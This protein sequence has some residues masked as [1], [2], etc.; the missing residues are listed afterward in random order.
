MICFEKERRCCETSHAHAQIIKRRWPILHT[1]STLVPTTQ[2]KMGPKLLFLLC[3]LSPFILFLLKIGTL[4]PLLVFVNP[5]EEAATGATVRGGGTD[6]YNHRSNHHMLRTMQTS[7]IQQQQQQSTKIFPLSDRAPSPVPLHITK[8]TID[9]VDRRHLQRGDTTMVTIQSSSSPSSSTQPTSSSTPKPPSTLNRQKPSS[10]TTTKTTVTSATKQTPT[11]TTAP[12]ESPKQI[13]EPISS[14][15]PSTLS[16]PLP[17]PKYFFV[18]ILSTCT[19]M[20]A[21]RRAHLRRWMRQYTKAKSTPTTNGNR[22]NQRGR[23]QQKQQKQPVTE[24]EPETITLDYLFILD[25]A[26]QTTT[27]ETAQTTMTKACE[28]EQKQFGD[29]LFLPMEASEVGYFNLAYKVEKV[30][31]YMGDHNLFDQYRYFVKTDDDSI[32]R[33]D[34]YRKVLEK[35]VDNPQ[36]NKFRQ[37]LST[38]TVVATK[39]NAPQDGSRSMTMN[40]V[41]NEQQQKRH[42]LLNSLYV[43][44]GSFEPRNRPVMRHGIRADI[45]FLT[46]TGLRTYSKYAAGAIYAVS[47]ALGKTLY[48]ASRAGPLIKWVNE[49]A[50]FGHWVSSYRHIRHNVFQYACL[51]PSSRRWCH[52]RKHFIIHPVKRVKTMRKMIQAFMVRRNPGLAVKTFRKR[53][54]G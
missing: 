14:P 29:M 13:H 48:G 5:W 18:A 43:Y 27:S 53:Y 6:R 11:P 38:A 16:P 25:N 23:P 17:A 28:E 31:R 19:S 30:L 20:G 4:M 41:Y 9:I 10:K 35:Q 49:D 47:S 12:R 34:A 33:Y 36:W 50:T 54:W 7:D 32:V 3:F 1:T 15:T 21:Q 46:D 52:S 22:K 2:N 40:V 24:T 44:S 42:F 37:S 8:P 45:D 26:T 39:S 51:G